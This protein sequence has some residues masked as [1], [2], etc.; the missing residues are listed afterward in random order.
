[1]AGLQC[2]TKAHN[3]Q[4]HRCGSIAVNYGWPSVA[5][6]RRTMDMALCARRTLSNQRLAWRGNAKAHNGHA[7]G[8][9]SYADQQRLSSLGK[10]KA[11]NGHAHGCRRTLATNGC[12][13]SPKPE[14][15]MPLVTRSTRVSIELAC[16]GRT[17]AQKAYATRR[18]SHAGH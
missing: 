12:S 15:D 8:C 10:V 7:L 18:S 11:Q 9:A 17:K 2:K 14:T 5:R 16:F 3:V 13:A 4:A 1:M 6:P